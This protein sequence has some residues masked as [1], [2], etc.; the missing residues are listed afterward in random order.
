MAESTATI[1]GINLGTVGD[2][3]VDYYTGDAADARD[4]LVGPLRD[5][6]SL[7]KREKVQLTA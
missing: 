1:T 5:P 6:T 7:S 4:E 2:G 3:S